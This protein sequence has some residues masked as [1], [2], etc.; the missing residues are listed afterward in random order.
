MEIERENQ[1]E[2]ERE[3]EREPQMRKKT[4][5]RSRVACP[6]PGAGLARGTRPVGPKSP[7]AG[8][9]RTGPRARGS[10]RDLLVAASFEIYSFEDACFEAT[11]RPDQR[12]SHLFQQ[13]WLLN[14]KVLN[15]LISILSIH[16]SAYVLLN[17]ISST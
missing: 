8:L 4:R 1:R 16:N 13:N 17:Y 9:S 15:I 11:Q 12:L 14:V 3:R 5:K 6:R 2:R 10:V 7:K